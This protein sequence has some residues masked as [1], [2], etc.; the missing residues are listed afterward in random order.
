MSMAA[1][2]CYAGQGIGPA[3]AGFVAHQLDYGL[4][5]VMAGT[6]TIVF[7]FAAAI[8]ISRRVAA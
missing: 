6:L 5:Y 1:F 4:L 3:I 8:L 7:G 2:S